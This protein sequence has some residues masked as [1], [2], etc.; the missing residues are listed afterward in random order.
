[1]RLGRTVVWAQG[2]ALAWV[3]GSQAAC[4]SGSDDKG[5]KAP[6][7]NVD[8][9]ADDEGAALMMCGDASASE[10]E[11]ALEITASFNVS[12]HELIICGGITMELANAVFDMTEKL[13]KG[14]ASGGTSDGLEF[15][16]DGVFRTETPTTVMTL[17]FTSSNDYMFAKTGEIIKENLLVS[18]NYFKGMH[19]SGSA[20]S[21]KV[22][23]DEVGPLYQLMKAGGPPTSPLTLSLDDLNK[24]PI[25]FGK[26]GLEG[27]II[28]HDVQNGV[29]VDYTVELAG[30]KL[31]DV[32]S[33]G[34]GYMVETA[35][36][37]NAKLHQQMEVTMWNL[38]YGSDTLGGSIE[39]AV[40][41]G[42]VDFDATFDYS[43]GSG[44][45]DISVQC[46]S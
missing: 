5:D 40:R 17:W 45:A 27:E 11:A 21:P 20:T 15:M 6:V 18:D 31:N 26:L 34:L 9:D 10:L 37:S 4:G 8:D 29:A 7:R 12:V 32:L 3:I 1:M 23:F 14:V 16:G 44:F 19:V 38:S 39:G 42:A 13:V 24:I 46:G 2:C 41:G 28:V 36:A 30:G 33:G 35:A 25:R 22:T 43:S